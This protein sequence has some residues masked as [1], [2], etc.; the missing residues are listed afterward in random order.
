MKKP[1]IKDLMI[2]SGEVSGCLMTGPL[3]F[4]FQK[5]I[6]VERDTLPA[7]SAGI[8]CVLHF[9][10]NIKENAS[11]WFL[12]GFIKTARFGVIVTIWGKDQMDI[13]PFPMT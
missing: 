8:G 1:G 3:K 2:V 7:E 12:T 11:G 9:P 13:L 5:N 4:H 10:K 6:P